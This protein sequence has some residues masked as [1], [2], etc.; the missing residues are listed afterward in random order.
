MATAMSSRSHPITPSTP[1]A[2][3]AVTL[4]EAFIRQMVDGLGGKRF[5]AV[6]SS[7]CRLASTIA[8]AGPT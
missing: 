6:D 3:T 4:M 5:T 2:T 1:P 8:N 7:M